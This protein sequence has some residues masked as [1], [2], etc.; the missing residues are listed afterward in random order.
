MVERHYALGYDIYAP[1][2]HDVLNRD[3]TDTARTYAAFVNGAN[4]GLGNMTAGRVVEISAGV[5]R[6]GSGMIGVTD[7]NEHSRTEHI[8]GFFAPLLIE[9]ANALNGRGA[10]TPGRMLETVRLIEEAGGISHINHSGRFTGGSNS[11]LTTGAAGSNNSTHVK[12]HVDIFLEYASCV[13]MEIINRLDNESRSDRI[14]WDNILKATAPNGR[15]VWGFSNDDS[16]STSE[17]GWNYNMHIMPE[18]SLEA[19]RESMETGTFFAVAPVARREGVNPTDR[20]GAAMR[21]G[22]GNAATEYL[23]ETADNPYPRITNI[24]VIGNTISITANDFDVIEWIADGVII[25]TGNEIDLNDYSDKINSYIRAQVKSTSA[26]VFVQP[27]GIS[28]A[29]IENAISSAYVRVIPGNTN[30]LTITVAELLSN[31]MT[32][33]ISET[34]TIRNNA[35]GNYSVGGYEVFIDTKG[36]DQI[37]QNYIVSYPY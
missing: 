35:E 23:R 14:L 1:A 2:D 19:F 7:S 18:L 9:N 16:H 4:D 11:N 30:E 29:A 28:E 25:A 22:G 3:F 17:V 27:F 13:G 12:T 34:Y 5:G 6:S 36:N 31:G 8:N 10:N 24:E 32:N 37:R 33:F 26:I 21:S 20:S 15:L